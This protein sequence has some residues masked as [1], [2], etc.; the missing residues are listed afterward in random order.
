[1]CIILGIFVFG[2]CFTFMTKFSQ[3][4]VVKTTF[5]YTRIQSQ[6]VQILAIFKSNRFMLQSN[7]S[8]WL[9]VVCAISNIIDTSIKRLI[10]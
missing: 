6:N 1:M 10:F 3:L 9:S 8:A 5:M 2:D 4:K 7:D